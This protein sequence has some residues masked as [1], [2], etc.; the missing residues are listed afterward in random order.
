MVGLDG[1]TLTCIDLD[2]TVLWSV[3]L[4]AGCHNL[5][6]FARFMSGEVALVWAGDG[7]P[8][9]MSGE[10]IGVASHPNHRDSGANPSFVPSRMTEAELRMRKMLD[11]HMAKVNRKLE[12]RKKQKAKE[13]AKD[14][15]DVQLLE[16]EA[17]GEKVEGKEAKP[18]GKD[19]KEQVTTTDGE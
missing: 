16:D 9:D 1:L 6:P 7:E 14:A 10:R 17:V 19:E 4:L 5:A 18:Q 11:G 15:E 8:L 2:G 12:N 13:I 3:G